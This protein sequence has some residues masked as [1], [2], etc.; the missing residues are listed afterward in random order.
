MEH[1]SPQGSQEYLSGDDIHARALKGIYEMRY[2][3]LNR[4][5]CQIFSANGLGI[6]GSE[7]LPNNRTGTQGVSP[8]TS[9]PRGGAT[10][11]HVALAAASV[12]LKGSWLSSAASS[13]VPFS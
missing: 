5:G 12:D 2:G 11:N 10:E 6:A 1:Y 9:M 7:R 3:Q 4:G 8:F 13:S